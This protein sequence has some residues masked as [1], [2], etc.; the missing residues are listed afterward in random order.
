MSRLAG[1]LDRG[2]TLVAEDLAEVRRQAQRLREVDSCL[3]ETAATAA[4]RQAYFE[5]LTERWAAESDPWAQ[6]MAERMTRWQAGLFVG[7]DDLGLPSDN[8]D[9]ERWFKRVKGHERRIHGRAHAGVRIVQEGPTLVLTLDAHV[10]QAQPFA[11]EQL[12]PYRD[13]KMPE[14]QRQALHRRTIMRRGRSKKQRPR[15]LAELERRYQGTS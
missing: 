8:L 12:R 10:L 6:D 7:D 13:A 11:A 14:C 1:L 2:L 15:L 9:L 5:E 4:E 3:K